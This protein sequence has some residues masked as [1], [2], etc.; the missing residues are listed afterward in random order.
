MVIFR[1][2]LDSFYSSC[3]L[4]FTR[5]LR[6]VYYT[7]ELPVIV[8]YGLMTEYG[9]TL[10]ASNYFPTQVPTNTGDITFDI[11]LNLINKRKMLRN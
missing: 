4:Q 10:I 11:E 5:S 2:M 6:V 3:Q 9:S 8:A 1:E 7:N